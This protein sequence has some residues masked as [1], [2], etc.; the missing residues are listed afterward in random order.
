MQLLKF[1]ESPRT[2]FE[3]LLTRW[4]VPPTVVVYDFACG[5]HK[6]CIAREPE[7]FKFVK[8][9]I[10]KLHTAGH[11]TCS[12]AYDPYKHRFVMNLNTQLCEQFNAKFTRKQPQLYKLSQVSYLFHMRHFLF[13]DACERAGVEI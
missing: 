5:E 7:Y 12:C 6:F 9:L 1:H 11:T 4:D 13:M 3:L 8:F 2:L 10:D